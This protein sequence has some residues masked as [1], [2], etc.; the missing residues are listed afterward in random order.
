MTKPKFRFEKP[1]IKSK[2]EPASKN[3][4]WYFSQQKKGLTINTI[5]E[6]IKSQGWVDLFD[7]APIEL[8]EVTFTE[9]GIYE[10]NENGWDKVIVDVPLNSIIITENGNYNASEGGWDT[11]IVEVP[12]KDTVVLLSSIHT[13]P[14]ATITSTINDATTKEVGETIAPTL[15]ATFNNGYFNSYDTGATSTNTISAGCTATTY[16]ILRDTTIISNSSTYTDSYKLTSGNT[17]YT[18]KITHSASASGIPTNNDGSVNTDIQFPSNTVT[19]NSITIIGAYKYFYGSDSSI[20]LNVRE[21]TSSFSRP[22][23]IN[24]NESKWFL[25]VPTTSTQP[26]LFKTQFETYKIENENESNQYEKGVILKKEVIVKD[27][28]DNDAQYYR[29]MMQLDNPLDLNINIEY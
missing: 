24:M 21:L 1:I 3:V 6:Y 15:T 4:L 25:Y 14:S 10:N 16:Q 7:T 26:T 23:S 17:I 12:V 13:Y 5:K 27:A 20:P 29:Y 8:G 22:S 2:T 18:C 28:G 19:S 9:N 11:I